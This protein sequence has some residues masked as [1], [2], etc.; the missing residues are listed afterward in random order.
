MKNQFLMSI[1]AL[2]ILGILHLAS[3]TK[4]EDAKP[5]SSIAK[6]MIM[7]DVKANLDL[8]NDTNQY[9]FPESRYEQVPSG[10]LLQARMNTES[11]DPNPNTILAYR[12]I[13]FSAKVGSDGTYTFEVYAGPSNT[14]VTIIADDFRYDQKIN[15]STWEEK[16]FYLNNVNISVIQNQT[17]IVDL[18]FNA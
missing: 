11:L 12:D 8:T 1:C 14:P 13:L 2:I 5:T 7:G 6:A 18:F 16:I 15:D 10:T 3:C 9:G 4:L 17:N